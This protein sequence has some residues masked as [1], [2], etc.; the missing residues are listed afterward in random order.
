MENKCV[1][2]IR[3]SNL[4]LVIFDTTGGSERDDLTHACGRKK[5]RNEIYL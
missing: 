1:T 5:L 4:I 2:A 3:L